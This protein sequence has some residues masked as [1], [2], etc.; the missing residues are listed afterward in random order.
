MSARH[1][2]TKRIS[3][4]AMMAALGVVILYMGSLISVADISMAVIASLLCIL[5]TIEYGRGAAFSLFFVTAV[6]SVVLLPQKS[7]SVMYALFFGYYPILKEMFERKK[8]FISWVLKELVFHAA[9]IAIFFAF[10]YLLAE[11]VQA[12]MIVYITGLILC[13][14][15]FVLYDIALT[16]LVSFYFFKLRDRFKFIR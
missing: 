11:N 14:V 3:V 1:N 7:P 10:K 15:I 12:H 4:C 8:K 13:E 5:A 9:L 2:H 16:R 6:L